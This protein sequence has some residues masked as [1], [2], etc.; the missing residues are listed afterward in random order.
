MPAYYLMV[1]AV[2][3][4]ITGISMKE[5]ANRP[6]KGATPAASDIQ[7]AKE[8]L[9]EHYDNIEQ[10]IDDIDQEI[11]ELQNKRSRLVQQHPR[12]DE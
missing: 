4:L 2:I 7:E 1:I 9:G 6:L 11:A 10:K 3:G 8:I 5:T 12:I